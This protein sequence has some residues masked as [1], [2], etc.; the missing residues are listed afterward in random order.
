MFT[1]TATD[2]AGNISVSSQV[3][4]PTSGTPVVIESHGVTSLVELGN[5]FYLEDSSGAGPSLKYL[6]ADVTAGQFGAWA[7]IGAEQTANGGYEVAWKVTGADQ[8]AVWYTDSGGNQTSSI[9][10]F[11]GS[12]TT[13]ESLET[14]FH[15]DLNGDGLIGIPARTSTSNIP[16]STAVQAA[17]VIVPSNDTFVF[18][19]GLGAETMANFV[20]IDTIE[21][22]R[23]PSVINNAQLAALLNDAQT[24]QSQTLFQSTNDG[25]DTM[26]NLG[27][28][29]SIMLT[30]V[31]VADLHA[32]N[33][34]IR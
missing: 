7:P 33:F 31:H 8:Y 1:A 3:A 10:V 5:H 24:D 9:G 4:N 6:G 15:Q 32:S 2:V 19:P 11:S 20:S 18:R 16:S 13:L 12:S 28:H 14:S 30:S 25:H 26:I 22:D 27:N 29:D 21:L 34:I 23:F 17:S